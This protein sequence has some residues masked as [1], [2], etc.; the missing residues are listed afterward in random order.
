MDE[1][2]SIFVRTFGV[3]SEGMLCVPSIVVAAATKEAISQCRVNAGSS[4]AGASVGLRRIRRRHSRT[5]RERDGPT[6]KRTSRLFISTEKRTK[7]QRHTTC[8]QK[9]KR[10]QRNQRQCDKKCQ[11]ARENKR[12]RKQRSERKHLSE[13]FGICTAV[14]V[15]KCWE[16]RRRH[17]PKHTHGDQAFQRWRTC[18]P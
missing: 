13:C 11:R 9:R 1:D 12:K 3:K 6:K 16:T 14:H 8:Q 7:R 18:R 5:D 15:G 10:K 17:R 2:T 4:P